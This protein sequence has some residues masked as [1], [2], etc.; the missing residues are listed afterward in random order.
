LQNLGRT[1]VFDAERQPWRETP[2]G[3][4]PEKG[5]GAFNVWNAGRY[6]NTVVPVIGLKFSLKV[7]G[8]RA[9]SGYRK[10]HLRPKSGK[11]HEIFHEG[12]Q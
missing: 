2:S 5:D 6:R 8:F 4:R 7:A 10:V 9:V 3:S 11:N 1:G 12:L